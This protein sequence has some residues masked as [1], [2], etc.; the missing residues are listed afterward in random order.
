MYLPADHKCAIRQDFATSL[1]LTPL[2]FSDFLVEF[3]G[4]NE[5]EM[6]Q[7]AYIGGK[8]RSPRG[9]ATGPP[10]PAR[11]PPGTYLQIGRKKITNRSCR[12]L[13]GRPGYIFE[14]FRNGHI[15]F[16]ILIFFKYKK[17]KNI[18]CCH[19]ALQAHRII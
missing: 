2:F 19:T 9:G 10:A 15:F 14:I 7:N 5:E 1:L 8:T 18:W 13:G 3:L 12:P 4:S 6:G 17:E 11:P 16:E